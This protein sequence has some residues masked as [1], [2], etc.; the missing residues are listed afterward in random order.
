MSLERGRKM[1][2]RKER[3]CWPTLLMGVAAIFVLTYLM[4]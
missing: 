1:Q 4:W 3:G 2:A